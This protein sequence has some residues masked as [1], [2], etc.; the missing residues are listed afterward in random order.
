MSGQRNNYTNMEADN[1]WKPDNRWQE[2]A[3][4]KGRRSKWI[5]SRTC[6]LVD[7]CSHRPQAIGSVIALIGLIAV[8][9][10]VGVTLAKKNSSK[11]SSST[12]GSTVKQTD[13]NDPSTFVKDS[14]LHQSFYGLAYTP[15]G[16]QLPDCGNNLS[17]CTVL[18]GFSRA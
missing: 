11:S 7:L 10:A 5:V 17:G 18:R 3:A 12:S 4:A 15:A 6:W 13:P 1:E 9:V 16:S 8:G 14:R 2:K